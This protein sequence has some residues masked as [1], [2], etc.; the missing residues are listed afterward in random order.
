[1][2]IIPVIT[3]DGSGGTMRKISAALV[4][5]ATA[6][7]LVTMS[8]GTASAAGTRLLN[9]PRGTHDYC[10]T[11]KGNSTANGTIVTTWDCTGSSLQ[12]WTLTSG[13]YIKHVASGKCLTPQGDASGTNGAVLTLWTCTNANSQKFMAYTTTD[14]TP[15]LFTI[16]GS[17]CITNKGDDIAN[18]VYLTLWTCKNSYA[19]SLACNIG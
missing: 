19:A 11:P 12:Q 2:I 8:G 9:V 7:S 15:Q 5:L 17:K 10:A 13:G 14:E 3:D 6:A 16:F 1:L 4:G 18:G